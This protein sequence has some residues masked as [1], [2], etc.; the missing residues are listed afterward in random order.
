MHILIVDDEQQFTKLLAQVLTP[1]GHHVVE[2]SAAAEGLS[3]LRSARFDLVI[4]DIKMPQIDGVEFLK[5]AQK[6]PHC[7]PFILLTGHAD[8]STAVAAL[9]LGARDYLTKPI[10][11]DE[12]RARVRRIEQEHELAERERQ[13]RAHA[14]QMERLAVLGQLAAGI[15][16]EINNPTAFIRGNAQ[17]LQMQLR[18]IARA[19]EAQAIADFDPVL[20][21]VLEELPETIGALEEGTNRIAAVTKGLVSFSGQHV[22]AEAPEPIELN[23]CVVQ[24]TSLFKARLEGVDVQFDLAADLPAVAL[25]RHSI[26]QALL[27]LLDNAAKAVE[28]APVKA[29]R[30][31][32]TSLPHNRI[33]LT[34]EDS[35]PGM[36]DEVKT[37]APE[38][39]F[40][41]RPAGKGF[42]LGLSAVHGVVVV[43][44]GGTLSFGD[45]DLGGARV[46]IELQAAAVPAE[47]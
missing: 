38:P 35:G 2:S 26:L 42:G 25:Y 19:H 23:D 10:H 28:K 37:H 3:F 32:T 4:S 18:R 47:V 45:S 6:L 31:A 39:F 20:A 22:L 17:L 9:R 16:H 46:H 8:L 12:V 24:I 44:H 30:I 1:V 36:Q 5:Q 21:E 13:A 33:A 14:R 15:A 11:M 7:P 29:I 40:T 41:Q 43:E 34:V 27:C